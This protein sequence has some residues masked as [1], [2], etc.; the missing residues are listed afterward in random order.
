[1]NYL[2]RR[3]RLL[4]FNMNPYVP[5]RLF[6]DAHVF[7][8]KFQGTRPFIQG[9]YTRLALMPEVELYLGA[10]D[11]ENLKKYFPD[12][13]GRV[14][15]VGY[16]SHSAAKRLLIEIPRLIRKHKIDWA[17]FQYICPPVKN[18]RH[19]VTTHDILFKD[20]PQDFPFLYRVV[21]GLAFKVSARRADLVTT[22]S[23]YSKQ[24]LEKHFRLPPEKVK[25]I[26]SGVIDPF[27][28]PYDK[29]A[30]QRKVEQRFGFRKYLLYVSRIEPRKNHALLLRAFLELGLYA[31]GYALVLLG[32]KDIDAP[33]FDAAMAQ[34]PAEARDSVLIRSGI[35]DEDI[36]DIFRGAELFVY[37]SRAEGFGLPPLEAAA[38]RVPV[39][40]SNATAMSDYTFFGEDSV[41]PS[42]YNG[43]K[44]KLREM[45][46][47]PKDQQRLDRIAEA[48]R[49]RYSWP[50]TARKF[51]ETLIQ[52][53]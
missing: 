18:C 45:L 49:E 12:S 8:G 52:T 41:D 24:A 38:A 40:C 53:Q 16:T 51:F 39:L 27:F 25:V 1:M 6:V 20:F 7:D 33:E 21:K 37:P 43:F 34:M 15:Y 31:R 28:L 17:H 14:H 4:Q 3:N 42:Q 30:I 5:V 46:E 44:D 22:V 11:T 35:A 29:P 36:Q 2:C 26:P 19:V 9:I 10:A 32:H 13:S 50:G 48:V 47:R 23:A